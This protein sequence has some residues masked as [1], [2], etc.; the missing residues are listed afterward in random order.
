MRFFVSAGVSGRSAVSDSRARPSV[1]A[2]VREQSLC[3]SVI[4]PDCGFEHLGADQLHPGGDVAPQHV[5]AYLERLHGAD[6]RDEGGG[7]GCL[8]LER[9]PEQV[10][11][12]LTG[13]LA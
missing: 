9:E 4:A 6:G 13:S 11:P 3:R 10:E 1:V 8:A 7:I 2:V 5:A 12:D